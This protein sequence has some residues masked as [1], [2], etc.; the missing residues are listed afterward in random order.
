MAYGTLRT[1][2][3]RFHYKD[4]RAVLDH[5]QQLSREIN[6][7]HPVQLERKPRSINL[8]KLEER[9]QKILDR[10]GIFSHFAPFYALCTMGHEHKQLDAFFGT[11]QS[12]SSITFKS[13]SNLLT[14]RTKSRGQSIR[15]T[16]PDLSSFLT[17]IDQI[18]K[19]IIQRKE[20]KKSRAL[21]LSSFDLQVKQLALKHLRGQYQRMKI[22]TAIFQQQRKTPTNQEHSAM[23]ARVKIAID[24]LKH[25]GEI[26]PTSSGDKLPRVEKRRD[27][28]P[29]EIRKNMG[30]VHSV[31][32][33]GHKWMPRNWRKHLSHQQAVEVGVEGLRRA[34]EHHDPTKGE[35]STYAVPNI[36]GAIAREVRRKM[37][38]V[39]LDVQ[40]RNGRTLHE[41]LGTKTEE[42]ARE[43][44]RGTIEKMF[45]MHRKGVLPARSMTIVTLRLMDHTLEEVGN[46]FKVTRER[47]RQIQRDAIRKLR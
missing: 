4:A 47:V 9:V 36:A 8:R 32:Q 14:G 25:R 16:Y 21:P 28:T 31:I 7:K 44:I 45:A 19:S 10:Q 35:L 30:L 22:V 5:V 33:R 43:D 24:K 6:A 26:P 3:S 12:T 34:I 29:D 20:P 27:A 41:K 42:P 1:Y 13:A 39:S 40:L 23:Y 37:K 2:F 11:G 18:S 15:G 38:L 46:H 17:E